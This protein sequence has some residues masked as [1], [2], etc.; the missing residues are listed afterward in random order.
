MKIEIDGRVVEISD[1][2][3]ERLS[4]A[5][6]AARNFADAMF[7]VEELVGMLDGADDRVLALAVE[8]F[9]RTWPTDEEVAYLLT[10]H[11]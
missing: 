1:S 2:V 10:G 9:D 4:R 11:E 7:E 3:K 8:L 5:I 6:Y